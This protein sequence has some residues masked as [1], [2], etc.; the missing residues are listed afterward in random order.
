MIGWLISTILLSCLGAVLY[1]L[2][3]NHIKS[4]LQRKLLIYGIV[5]GSLVLPL[6]FSIYP[7]VPAPLSEE[8]SHD[9]NAAH[10]SVATFPATVEEY[11]HCQDP[12][13]SDQVMFHA[14]R[15]YDTILSHRG[16]FYWAFG[17]I[18]SILL[19]LT[20][21]R[22]L[23]LWGYAARRQRETIVVD[24][25]RLHLLVGP[26][27][28][29]A[30]S[31]RLFR[32][33]ILWDPVLENLSAK[34]RE[35]VMQHETSHL[36]QFNTWENLALNLLQCLW[37]ANPAFYFFRRELNTISEFI[38][39]DAGAAAM[40][41][42]VEY[43]RLLLALKSQPQLAMVQPFSGKRIKARISRL[44]DEPSS[45]T[46]KFLPVVLLFVVVLSGFNFVSH[47]VI[48]EQ[49]HDLEV[50]EYMS[51]AHSDTGQTSF[52]APCTNEFLFSRQ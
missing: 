47:T 36:K 5:I 26:G 8:T 27:R 44:I 51:R 31:F 24:G 37:F 41:S 17:L 7:D 52:C 30:G 38:A 39:D 35:A 23:V 21:A 40:G 43:A 32:S 49:Q 18:V 3:R 22:I 1:V 42:R 33:F 46:W 11:C 48:A 25:K 50:Y 28:M 2:V 45:P 20:A 10:M 6:Y 13:Q 15:V 16:N 34:E 29:L 4:L 19:V 9:L 12:G 14:S